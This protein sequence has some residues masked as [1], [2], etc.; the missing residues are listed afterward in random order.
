MNKKNNAKIIHYIMDGVCY[1]GTAA[2]ICVLEDRLGYKLK[3]D[4]KKLKVLKH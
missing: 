3:K 4:L 2:T 1:I